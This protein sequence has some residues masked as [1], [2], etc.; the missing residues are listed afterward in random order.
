[1]ADALDDVIE[2]VRDLTVAVELVAEHVRGHDDLRL[3]VLEHGL[4]CSLVALNDGKLALWPA[5]QGA[6]HGKLRRDA[7]DEV[8]ARAVGKV[9]EARI[10]ECLLDHARAGR[11]AVRAGDEDDAHPPREHAEHLR[12][13]L[14]RHAAG[15]RRAAAA[16]QPQQAARKLTQQYCKKSS[17]FHSLGS[18]RD[19]FASVSRCSF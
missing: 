5:G 8:R 19:D 18:L 12:V 16:Q 7:G 6:V 14:E 2:R 10:G 1:M 13:H 3:E 9:I 4:G 11:L 17:D 15:K